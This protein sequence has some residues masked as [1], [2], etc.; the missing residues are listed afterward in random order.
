[1]TLLASGCV[2]RPVVSTPPASC[3]SLIPQGWK[4]PVAAEPIPTNADV[5][6]WLGK[7]LTDAMAAAIIAPWATGFVGQAGALEKQ[8]GRTQDAIAVVEN[9]ERMV[10][11]ARPES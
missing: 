4:E 9:C 11:A 1:M 5:S 3:S 6:G 10:N 2:D 8:A 7:P